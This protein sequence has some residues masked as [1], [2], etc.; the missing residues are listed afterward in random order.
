M[1]GG[2]DPAHTSQ[3]TVELEDKVKEITQESSPESLESAT[4]LS[5]LLIHYMSHLILFSEQQLA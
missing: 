1:I 2:D 4:K 5:S 3:R